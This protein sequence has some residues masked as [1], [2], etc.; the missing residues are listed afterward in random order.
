MPARAPDPRI[1]ERIV[2]CQ[3]ALLHRVGQAPRHLP[4]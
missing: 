3:K 2:T 1:A 4:H